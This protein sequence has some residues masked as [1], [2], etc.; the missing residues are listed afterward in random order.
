METLGRWLFFLSLF[1][2]FLGFSFQWILQEDSQFLGFFLSFSSFCLMGSVIFNFHIYKSFFKSD[3]FYFSLKSLLQFFLF[4]VFFCTLN[5]S[6]QWILGLKE[7]TPTPLQLEP[8]PMFITQAQLKIYFLF[9]ILPFMV[10]FWALSVF[11][12]LYQS[13]APKKTTAV[14]HKNKAT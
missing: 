2:L 5:W 1:V 13:V 11:I 9:F 6:L 7:N 3:F 12:K 10:F 8:T 14:N 4:L